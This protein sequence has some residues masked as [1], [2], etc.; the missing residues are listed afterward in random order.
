MRYSSFNKLIDISIRDAGGLLYTDVLYSAS[1][2]ANIIMRML[3]LHAVCSSNGIAIFYKENYNKLPDAVEDKKVKFDKKVL[4]FAFATQNKLLHDQLNKK[5]PNMPYD[6]RKWVYKFSGEGNI[7]KANIYPAV[8]THSVLGLG[9]GEKNFQINK[10]GTG[11]LKSGSL[12]RKVK[13]DD[14]GNYNC[15]A[16]LTNHTAG[17]YELLLEGQANFP[18]YMDTR[19]ELTGKTG[20][21][22]IVMANDYSY[23]GASNSSP[24]VIVEPVKITYQF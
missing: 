6:N 19:N 8:F 9:V 22:E 16:D 5:L 18:V 14:D 21:I 7:G 24:P 15:T 2:E 3:N 20:L 12:E 4:H 17:N 23:S 10:N 13:S 11:I 1:A